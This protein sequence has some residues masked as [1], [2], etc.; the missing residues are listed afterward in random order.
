MKNSYETAF[1]LFSLLVVLHILTHLFS[2]Q[3]H[4]CW[5][6]QEGDAVPWI[7]RQASR[8]SDANGKVGLM[9]KEPSLEQI[10]VLLPTRSS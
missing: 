6:G 2:R 9:D 3:V 8:L 5:L 7:R 1:I 4:H 10:E